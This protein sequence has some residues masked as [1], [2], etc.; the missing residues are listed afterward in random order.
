MEVSGQLRAPAAL[1][2][3]KEPPDTHSD[4]MVGGPQSQSGHGV[5]EKNSRPPAGMGTQSSN[6]PASSQLLN[7]LS[8]PRYYIGVCF[9]K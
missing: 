5:E 4:R 3:Q 1:P 9:G 8:Y 6:H 2:P 7:Q